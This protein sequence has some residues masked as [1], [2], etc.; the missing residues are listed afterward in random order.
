M[1]HGNIASTVRGREYVGPGSKDRSGQCPEERDMPNTMGVI[2]HNTVI[3]RYERPGF[4][5]LRLR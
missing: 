5:F 1:S 3:Q 4:P 2:T